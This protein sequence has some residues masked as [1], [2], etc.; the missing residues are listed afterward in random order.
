[1]TGQTRLFVD[2][3]RVRMIRFQWN[4][5]LTAHFFSS[6]FRMDVLQSSLTKFLPVGLVADIS[7]LAVFAVS[8]LG[9]GVY[10]GRTQLVNILIY[11]YVGAALV[12]TFP[13]G[14]L[15]FSPYGKALAFIAVLVLLVFVGD[16]LFDIHISSA[17]S[18]FF[19]RVLVMSFLSVGMA[20]SVLLTL[21][22]RADALKYL[23]AS[24]YGYFTLPMAQV[25]W[26]SL[27]LVFLL[28]VNKRLR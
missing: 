11:G 27:P 26:M 1:M 28:F 12:R 23:S 16:Y 18:D 21:L 10:L 25:L 22:P 6:H 20:V 3:A 2:D 24:T 9:L 19:W 14:W 15:D 13:S 7:F 8:C 4:P 5:R 17:G